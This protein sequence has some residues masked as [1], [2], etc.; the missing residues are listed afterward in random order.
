MPSLVTRQSWGS[1]HTV[2]IWTS[3][4]VSVDAVTLSEPASASSVS[5]TDEQ[6]DAVPDRVEDDV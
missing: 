1:V 3:T 6:R 2:M 4:S 5:L